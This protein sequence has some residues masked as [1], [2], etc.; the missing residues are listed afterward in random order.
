[1]RPF[2]HLLAKNSLSEDAPRGEELLNGHLS[3]VFRSAA[4]LLDLRGKASLAA[5]G[6]PISLLDC[7]G[8][9]VRLAALLHD[10]GKCSEPFQWMVRGK[11][12]VQPMRHEAIT[13]WLCWPGQ[14]LSNFLRPAAASDEEF[15]CALVTAAGHHRKFWSKSFADDEAGAG[16]S[17][18]LLVD[19]PD[20]V[21]VLELLRVTL[22]LKDGA[23]SFADPVVVDLG[24]RSHPRRLFQKWESEFQRILEPEASLA[25]LTSVAKAL[26]LAADVVGSALPRAGEKT[27]WVRSELSRRPSREQLEDLVARRLAGRSPRPFQLRVAESSA[28]VTLVR[29]GCGSGKTAAAYLWAARQ[30]SGRQ[31]WVT[32]PT[33]GTATEGFRDYVNDADV[34]GRLEHSRA[35]VDVDLF[36]LDDGDGGR[37]ELDRLAALRAWGSEVVTCTVDT[38][39][40]LVQNQRRGLYAWPCLADSAIVFD[41]VHSY[42]ET[43]FGALLR[44][45]EALPGIPVLLMTASLPTSRL[46]ALQALVAKVHGRDLVILEG[47]AELERLPR[48]QYAGRGEE[49]SWVTVRESLSKGEKV[50]WVS[51]TVSRAVNVAKRAEAI[52]LSSALYHSR[53][54]YIDRVRRHSEVIEAF[55]R[56]G[57]AFASTTQV[58]EMSLDISADLLVTDLAPIPSM[59]QRLGRLNRRASPDN[60][61]SARPVRVV[62]FRGEPYSSEDLQAAQR[63]LEELPEGAFSQQDL[64]RCWRQAD[65]EVS[66]ISSAWLDGGFLTEVASLREP[67]PGMTVLLERDAIVVRERPSCV[68]EL[69]V[70]MGPLKS[71][72]WKT[73]PRVGWVPVAPSSWLDYDER[74]GG[75]WRKA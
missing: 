57:P 24:R 14:P 31:L 45:L 55:R 23:P 3:L 63:W 44:F 30:Q 18:R 68:T 34:A 22:G 51:N 53:Y 36:S 29:A 56:T 74:T 69:V 59:I 20:F 16:V 5:A 75:E 10:V 66:R 33:T 8:R 50:L 1:M 41:E 13:L 15:L 4:E 11:A 58:S 48:Y 12:V 64:V 2:K 9:V 21:T 73:W 60:P 54:R 43:L 28:P 38:V 49:E 7:L 39:L 40:G 26:V 42:D 47:P 62:P 67:S 17:C 25:R 70:P 71:G 32:Y 65:E 6:L 52:G 46:K 72:E 19:H 37:R 61:L 27:R 35:Q